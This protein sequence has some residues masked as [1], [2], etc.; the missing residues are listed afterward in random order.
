M[1]ELTKRRRNARAVEIASEVD[2]QA[3]GFFRRCLERAAM[4]GMEYANPRGDENAPT[5]AESL[6]NQP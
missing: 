6:G 3:G 5:A 1:D 4:L 2:P